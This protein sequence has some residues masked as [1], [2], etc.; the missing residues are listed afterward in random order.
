[1]PPVPPDV[2]EK[3]KRE[4][5]AQRWWKRVGNAQFL[6]RPRPLSI[7]NTHVDEWAAFLY[8]WA[9]AMKKITS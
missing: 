3:P 9:R 7:V 4:V 5:S 2:K 1:M 8:C 6:L